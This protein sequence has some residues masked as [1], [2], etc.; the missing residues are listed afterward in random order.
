MERIPIN[1][2]SEGNKMPS[3]DPGKVNEDKGEEN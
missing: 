3:D 1:I 2:G